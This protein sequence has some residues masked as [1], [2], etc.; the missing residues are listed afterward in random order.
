MWLG[1]NE[2][3]YEEMCL[4]LNTSN[5]LLLSL[6]VFAFFKYKPLN[7]NFLE[8]FNI[9]FSFFFFKSYQMNEILSE[10]SI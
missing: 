2:L 5:I 9:H 3:Q 1:L 6:I 8:S 7:L 4:T 10:F